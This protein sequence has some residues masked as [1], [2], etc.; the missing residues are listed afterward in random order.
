MSPLPQS[1]GVIWS[2]GELNIRGGRFSENSASEGGGVIH[3]AG[4]CSATLT[5]GVF[6]NNQALNGGMVYVGD[7]AAVV[8]QGGSAWKNVAKNGGGAIY[9]DSNGVLSVSSRG[10]RRSPV[11]K[12]ST[13]C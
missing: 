12:R 9:A 2:K 7:D 1:G 4:S 8:I 3:A 6:E 11:S 10:L 5:A 13:V